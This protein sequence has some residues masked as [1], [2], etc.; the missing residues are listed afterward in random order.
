MTATINGVRLDY[1]DTGDGVPLLCLP[2]GMGLDATTLRVPGILDLSKNGVRVVVPDQ[3]GHGR[4]ERCRPEEYSHANWAA[5]ANALADSLGWPQFAL[6]GHSYGGFIALEYAVR[7]PERLAHL[8]LVSTSAGPVPVQP[9][10]IATDAHLRDHF[11]SIW[12]RFFVGADK[13]WP[14][15]E[16]VEFTEAAYNA[17]FKRELPGY[18]LR[19]L[20]TDLRMPTLL[21]VGEND[22]YRAHMEW[23]ANQMPAATLCVLKDVG[24]F[25]FLEATEVFRSRVGQFLNGDERCA[26]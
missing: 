7:W 1:S 20:V 26:T 23:L 4:S 25:P 21:I 22:C 15:F 19:K 17:A 3:R 13:H 10:D 2:G 16:R 18:D 24:H 5:D 8:I 12:P 9:A 6:L 14:L 11:R